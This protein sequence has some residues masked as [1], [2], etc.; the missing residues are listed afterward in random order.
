M[1]YMTKRIILLLLL[2]IV[3]GILTL[4]IEITIMSPTHNVGQL[5]GQLLVAGAV[6][7]AALIAGGI[8]LHKNK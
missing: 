5:M 1:A 7:L 2:A 8:Y 4:F 6:A 3:A